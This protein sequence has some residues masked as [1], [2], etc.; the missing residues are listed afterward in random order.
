MPSQYAKIKIIHNLIK[1]DSRKPLVDL[2]AHMPQCES[3]VF[4]AQ[5]PHVKQVLE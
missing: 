1:R 2:K 3:P 4:K 5:N